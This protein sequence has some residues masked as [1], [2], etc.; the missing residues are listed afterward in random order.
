MV[1]R[2]NFTILLNIY[3]F[4]CHRR[5]YKIKKSKN[6]KMKICLYNKKKKYNKS[7]HKNHNNKILM[8]T[9]LHLMIMLLYSIIYLFSQLDFYIGV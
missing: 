8:K 1:I 9:N 7:N 6:L 3:L 5:K 4:L 2:I